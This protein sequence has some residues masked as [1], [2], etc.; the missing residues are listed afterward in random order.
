MESQVAA[1]VEESGSKKAK[2]QSKRSEYV[3]K[4]GDYT[5]HSLV[6]KRL[7]KRGIS[8]DAF[9]PRAF[10]TFCDYIV[11]EILQGASDSCLS[12][13][14]VTINNDDIK[15][16]IGT[17]QELYAMFSKLTFVHTSDRFGKLPCAM[18]AKK[19]VSKRRTMAIADAPKAV[20][21]EV[22]ED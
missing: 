11:S 20:E 21:V 10:A 15:N 14:R 5:A 2:K 17:D 7:K 6:K 12:G 13:K 9:V 16:S 3:I 4:Y 1:V 18:P 19:H 22:E 8:C